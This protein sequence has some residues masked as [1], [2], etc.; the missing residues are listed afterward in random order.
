MSSKVRTAAL[1]RRSRRPSFFNSRIP[2]GLALHLQLGPRPRLAADAQVLEV[3]AV[4]R[5]VAEDLVLAGLVLRRAVDRRHAVPGCRLQGE[6]R[7]DEVR[8]AE[9]HEVGAAGGED[10]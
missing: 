8:A 6:E 10:G 3:G 9:R 1:S 5:A 4:A 2:C 7:I